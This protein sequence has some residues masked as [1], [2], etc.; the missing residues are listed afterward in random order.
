[1]TWY[2]KL[3]SFQNTLLPGL[4]W[5]CRKQ[6]GLSKVGGGFM[7][8]RSLTGQWTMSNIWRWEKINL[9]EDFSPSCRGEEKVIGLIYLFPYLLSRA[10]QLFAQTSHS[11]TSKRMCALKH[12]ADKRTRRTF[13]LLFHYDGVLGELRKTLP[14]S[15]LMDEDGDRYSQAVHT[16]RHPDNIPK[17]L[18]K[19]SR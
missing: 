10:V 15:G 1:M 12:L 13:L 4:L 2:K 5:W 6:P 19:F 17:S 18:K 14:K 16:L 8:E 3:S 9:F 11:N 7:F